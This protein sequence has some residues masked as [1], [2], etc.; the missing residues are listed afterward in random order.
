MYG[1]GLTNTPTGHALATSLLYWPGSVAG[2]SITLRPDTIHPYQLAYSEALKRSSLYLS[3]LLHPTVVPLPG[4]L[5][6][7]RSDPDSPRDDDG[8]ATPP[9]SPRTPTHRVKSQDLKFG[10]D[11]ILT[12]GNDSKDKSDG[13]YV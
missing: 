9:E 8:G 11:R 7:P 12:E 10:I 5:M 13:N 2:S 3:D 4:T 6:G 1:S